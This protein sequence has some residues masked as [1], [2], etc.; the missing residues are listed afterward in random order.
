ML[1]V[2]ED[3]NKNQP[4]G[5]LILRIKSMALGTGKLGPGAGCRHYGTCYN[6]FDQ[7]V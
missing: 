4:D 5:F 6:R 1:I 7:R 2:A 3:G